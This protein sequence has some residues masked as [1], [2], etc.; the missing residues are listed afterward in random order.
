MGVK[1][2]VKDKELAIEHICSNKLISQSIDCSDCP[3]RIYAKHTDK[4]VLGVGNI[5]ADYIFVL[6]TY[7]VYAKIGYTTM[8]T[9]LESKY[10][11]ITGNELFENV[12][13]TR[14]IK[15]Y[16]NTEYNVYSQSIKSCKQYLNYELER[17]NAKTVVF[18]G[19]TY[20]D[21]SSNAIDKQYKGAYK[22]IYQCYSPGIFFYDNKD[23]ANSFI[24]QLKEAIQ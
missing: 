4:V 21:Y 16:N 11:E 5:Y 3:L 10:K 6:P 1:R 15:C 7:D 23:L 18:F 13:V 9:M 2:K 20:I 14:L 12:Y 22:K 24:Q 17:I 19:N 8:L